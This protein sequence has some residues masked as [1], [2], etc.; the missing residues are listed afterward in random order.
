MHP[1]VTSQ[2]FDNFI[3]ALILISSGLLAFENVTNPDANINMVSAGVKIYLTNL[4]VTRLK[5]HVF[6]QIFAYPL[7]F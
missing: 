7:K 5:I 2:Y 3:L 1:I 4:A 6:S